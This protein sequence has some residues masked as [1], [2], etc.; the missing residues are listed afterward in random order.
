MMDAIIRTSTHQVSCDL[1][2]EVAILN[3]DSGVYYGLDGV[4]ARVWAL[5]SE[6]KRV[7]EVRDALLEEFDVDEERCARD[8]QAL[9]VRLAEAGLIEVEDAPG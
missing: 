3:L 7:S 1:T 4:G 5:I 2:G 6:P 9:L 8:L